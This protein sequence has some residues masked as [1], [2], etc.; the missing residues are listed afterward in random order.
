M[1]KSQISKIGFPTTLLI[2]Y[3]FCFFKT[4]IVTLFFFSVA[5]PLLPKSCILATL[6]TPFAKSSLHIIAQVNVPGYLI[7]QKVYLELQ[8]IMKTYYQQA[9]FVYVLCTLV[10]PSGA[11]YFLMQLVLSIKKKKRMK[12]Y[13][14]KFSTIALTV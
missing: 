7:L 3:P 4:R 6:K 12:S 1:T 10:R 5:L 8:S 9:L 14:S 13:I 2:K 11:F